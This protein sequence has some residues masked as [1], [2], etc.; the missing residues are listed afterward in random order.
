MNMT[1]PCVYHYLFSHIPS[2]ESEVEVKNIAGNLV[3][4]LAADLNL[5]EDETQQLRQLS[6]D[7]T[8]LSSCADKHT[9]TYLSQLLSHDLIATIL[10]FNPTD[11]RDD[12]RLF[13]QHK[14]NAN[15]PETPNRIGETSVF[16]VQGT[17]DADL[18]KKIADACIEKQIKEPLPCCQFEWGTLYS[19][20]HAAPLQD[21]QQT[22]TYVLLVAEEEDLN[23]GDHFLSYSFPILESIR[24]KLIFEEQESRKF[25]ANNVSHEQ[26]IKQLLNKIHS[27][28]SDISVSPSFEDHLKQVDTHQAALYQSIA[29]TN[30]LLLTLDINILNF[31]N[32]LTVLS[33]ME[34]TLLTPL[35]AEFRFVCQQ[36]EYD[37]KY[38]KFLLPGMD[39]R[40][41]LL[42]LQ[43]EWQRKAAEE[44][45]NKI[46]EFTNALIFAFGVALGIGQMLKD[47]DW[48]SKFWAML[49]GGSVAFA[50]N[51]FV[52]M[53]RVKA[54]WEA[55]GWVGK[56]KK[57]F[58][59]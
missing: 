59:K 17:P 47:L 44:R 38:I 36:I 20:R 7:V 56:V 5:K 8:L 51:R 49:L 4:R 24:H 30:A 1:K 32:T 55:F 12:P 21:S 31:E 41:E 46:K 43:I 2:Y 53:E 33:P 58:E 52:G 45:S 9:E 50:L 35:I 57:Q 19:L 27:A 6:A 29:E 42:R 40:A 18:V 16:F 15:F 34:D 3:F 54:V 26:E 39:K 37:L 13:L 22:E 28:L 48:T 10:T 25:K 14:R 23:K 11:T